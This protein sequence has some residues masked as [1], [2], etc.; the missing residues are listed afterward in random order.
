MAADGAD[1]AALR[2]KLKRKLKRGDKLTRRDRDLLL[3]SLSRRLGRRPDPGLQNK[4]QAI[5]VLMALYKASKTAK[6]N[7]AKK[8]AAHCGISRAKVYEIR[9]RYP[10]NEPNI[11]AELFPMLINILEQA[12]GVASRPP[13]VFS[14]GAAAFALGMV[15]LL[16]QLFAEESK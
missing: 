3:R 10:I 9:R 5:A 8:V 16:K 6:I 13:E 12:T 4:D 14:G 7:N 1:I 11:D 2:M 15:D